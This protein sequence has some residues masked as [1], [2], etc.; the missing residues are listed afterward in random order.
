MVVWSSRRGMSCDWAAQIAF[1]A[2]QAHVFLKGGSCGVPHSC[3]AVMLGLDFH[4]GPA[5]LAE[6]GFA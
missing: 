4:W 6:G 2:K 1:A 5:R 3:E